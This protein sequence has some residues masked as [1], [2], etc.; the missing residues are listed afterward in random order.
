MLTA[1]SIQKAHMDATD[2]DDARKKPEACS[3]LIE[4]FHK[5]CCEP[6]RSPRL[7]SVLTDLAA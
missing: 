4:Y 5:M 6:D 1:E 7:D 3:H 2:V